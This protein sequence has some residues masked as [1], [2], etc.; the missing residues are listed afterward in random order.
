[1]V[2]EGAVDSI[3]SMLNKAHVGFKIEK[4]IEMPH[5]KANINY[6]YRESYW[7]KFPAAKDFQNIPVS[8]QQ[9]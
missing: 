7:E 5:K 3:A 6:C 4:V 2:G 1:M 9:V 8:A